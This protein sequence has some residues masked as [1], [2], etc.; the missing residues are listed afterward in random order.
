[1][2]F[3]AFREWALAASSQAA[4]RWEDP[5]ADQMPILYGQ[6]LY[7][8]RHEIAAPPIDLRHSR[9]HIGWLTQ[10]V[11]MEVKNRSLQRLCL[12][13]SAWT[14]DADKYEDLSSDPDRTEL[15]LNIVAEA[16]R[17]EVWQAR[18]YRDKSGVPRLDPWHEYEAD[19]TKASLLQLIDRA[20][21]KGN[22]KRGR[23]VPAA[24]MVLGPYDVP[25]DFFPDYRGNACGPV[26]WVG[27]DQVVSS[28]K[29][30]F[31]TEQP[32]H[33]ILSVCHVFRP[34]YGLDA[35]FDGALGALTKMANKEID[36]P[37]IGERSHFFEGPLDSGRLHKHQVLWSQRNILCELGLLGPP[38]YF[39]T[40]KLNSLAA[41]QHAR[42]QRELRTSLPA[43]G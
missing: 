1:M 12:R 32:D 29:A 5:D 2:S 20:L 27:E 10:L 7:D 21:R 19:T 4:S 18:I 41:T 24:N 11:P 8:D 30:A 22:G 40:Q 13:I 43:T 15:L 33:V 39:K 28:Y 31:R 26:D 16:G 17:S 6:D 3:E 14:G 42:L 38:G 34:D 9:G 37:R 25:I 23:T 36:G 35:H